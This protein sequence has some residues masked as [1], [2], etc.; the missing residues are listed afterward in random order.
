[1]V[2]SFAA[3]AATLAVASAQPSFVYKFVAANAGGVDGSIHIKYAG[4]NSSTATI[5][6]ALDFSR[7][8]QSEIVAFDAN[9]TSDVVTGWKWH[10]HTNWSSPQSSDSFKQC[11]KA[12]T[13]LHYDPLRACGPVSEYNA[14]PECAAKIK[15]YACNPANYTADPLACEKGD[16]SGK[17]GAFKLGEDST[18]AEQWTDDHFPLPSENTESWSIVLHAMCGQESR[19]SCAHRTVEEAEVDQST[20]VQQEAPVPAPGC[21]A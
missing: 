7:V 12:A 21:G 3:L 20:P 4:E 14:E 15:S 18:V 13:G 11:A 5:T 17:F 1:M 10:I 19:I 6:A 8:N 9:C 2:R 16:L